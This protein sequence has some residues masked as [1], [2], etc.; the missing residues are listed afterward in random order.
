MSKMSTREWYDYK[1]AIETAN[2]MEDK[3]SLRKIKMRLIAEYGLDDDDVYELLKK[4][5]YTV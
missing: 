2:D 3:D 5:R 4:F 1:S